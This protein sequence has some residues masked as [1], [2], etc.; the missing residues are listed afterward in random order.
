MPHPQFESDS[1]LT[2]QTENTDTIETAIE[3]VSI[4]PMPSGCYQSS[5]ESCIR[6]GM[7]HPTEKDT[8]TTREVLFN[9]RDETI[10]I[11]FTFHP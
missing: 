5:E 1:S 3:P 11:K 4:N 2:L 8:P 7:E 9:I 10:R 6:I